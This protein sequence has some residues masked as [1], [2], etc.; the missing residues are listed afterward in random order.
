MVVE[1][2]SHHPLTPLAE[3]CIV[4]YM[5]STTNTHVLIG[6]DSE[7][8]GFYRSEQD[9]V[10]ALAELVREANENADPQADYVVAAFTHSV[11]YGW[12]GHHVYTHKR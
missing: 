12:Q 11:G 7:V 10:S 9:A 4:T 8:I 3:G 1:T 5:E 6:N 2:F